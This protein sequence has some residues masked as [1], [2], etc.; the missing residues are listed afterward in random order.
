[1]PGNANHRSPTK[2]WLGVPFDLGP[3]WTVFDDDTT[4]PFLLVSSP[5][6][7]NAIQSSR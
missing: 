4:I 2:N 3:I 1:M 6:K 7:N 5:S